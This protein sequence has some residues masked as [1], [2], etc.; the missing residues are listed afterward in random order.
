MTLRSFVANYASQDGR[1]IEIRETIEDVVVAKA[2]MNRRTP[3]EHSQ[4]WRCQ[5]F[6]LTA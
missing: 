3:K 4:E 6:P 2:A 5:P 1:R